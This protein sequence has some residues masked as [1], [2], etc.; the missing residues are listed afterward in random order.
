MEQV[1][2]I[3]TAAALLVTALGGLSLRKSAREK[4]TGE[5]ANAAEK[6]A[7]RRLLLLR[8]MQVWLV[9]RGIFDSMPDGLR[10]DLETET[11]T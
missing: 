7:Y 2:P 9:E 6:A 8:R 5:R 1:A 4:E 10:D 3:L 11:E